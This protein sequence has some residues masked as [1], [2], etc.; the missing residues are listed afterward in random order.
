VGERYEVL[1]RMD[2][3]SDDAQW[4]LVEP[5]DSAEMN[6]DFPITTR[7][8]ALEPSDFG[9]RSLSASATFEESRRR[10]EAAASLI[11]QSQAKPA[12]EVTL[13]VE[14][15]DAHLVTFHDSDPDASEQYDRLAIMLIS[16]AIQQPI[17]RVLIASAQHGEGRT[18]VTLNL[19]GALARARQRVLVVDSD[20]LR[21]SVLRLLGIDA[22]IGLAE[23]IARGLPAGSAAMRILPYNF[24]VLSTRARVENSA[25]LLA[26]PALQELLHT[27]DPDYDFIL[28]D[29]PPLLATA[30]TRLLIRL[31]QTTLLVI[32]QGKTSSAQMAQAI[33]PLT[34]EDIF[35]VVLNR[36]VPR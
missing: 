12:R 25:E 13:A 7:S 29:S 3:E 26:S 24:T 1:T 23:V 10:R 22:E 15:M 34:A 18:C 31:T 9:R 20:L 5:D 16:A 19:A 2:K 6:T 36:A 21:P 14:R 33:T 4:T 27:F 11:R 17:K 8:Q 32:R 28:F 30:D 35:G